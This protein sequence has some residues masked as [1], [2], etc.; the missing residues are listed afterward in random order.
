MNVDWKECANCDVTR[1]QIRNW[2]DCAVMS[3]KFD[4]S[5]EPANGIELHMVTIE[6]HTRRSS[7][8]HRK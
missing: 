2:S 4:W 6:N 8:E 1:A 3:M 7:S 5:L